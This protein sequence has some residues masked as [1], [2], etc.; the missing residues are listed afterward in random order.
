ME[1]SPRRLASALLPIIVFGETPVP[2]S[3]FFIALPQ[4][5]KKSS[6]LPP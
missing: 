3:R 4:I 5:F 6:L 2:P 1:R